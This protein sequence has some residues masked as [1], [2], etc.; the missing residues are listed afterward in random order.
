MMFTMFVQ[1]IACP[2]KIVDY[3]I[4]ISGEEIIVE[5]KKIVYA[6]MIWPSI[7]DQMR[8]YCRS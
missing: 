3:L 8:K 1:V 6:V 7:T 2:K 5:Q 4:K